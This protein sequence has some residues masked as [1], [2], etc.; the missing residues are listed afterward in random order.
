MS[1]KLDAKSLQSKLEGLYKGVDLSAKKQDDKHLLRNDLIKLK[2]REYYDIGHYTLRSPG[3]DLLEF[4]DDMMLR[5]DP[6]SKA[7]SHIPPSVVFHF[8]FEH[9]YPKEVFDK[10]YN[11]GIGSYLRESLKEYY[12]TDDATYW[13]QI[14][15]KRYDW[16]VDSPH[17]SIEFESMKDVVDYVKENFGQ[18]IS[19]HSMNVKSLLT[20]DGVVEG[21]FEHM[22]WRGKLAGWSLVFHPKDPTNKMWKR[23]KRDKVQKYKHKKLH[24]I[25]VVKE[26]LSTMSIVMTPKGPFFGFEEVGQAFNIKAYNARSWTRVSKKDQFFEISKEQYRKYCKKNNIEPRI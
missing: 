15:T 9:Q 23:F 24:N 19:A 5:Q 12:Y 20:T 13:G 17:T 3:N 26:Y 2:S 4:Y 18:T 22:F 21:A 8:R 11:F 10:K 16:L 6:T 1:K 25:D 7:Y 14:Y